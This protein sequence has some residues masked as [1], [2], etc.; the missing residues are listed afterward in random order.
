MTNT[1][2]P[3]TRKASGHSPA[4]P[5]LRLAAVALLSAIGWIAVMAGDTVSTRF[6]IAFPI[7]SHKVL[8]SFGS[9]GSALDSIESMLSD[10]RNNVCRIEISEIP[11]RRNC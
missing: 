1:S 3:P 9:N 10:R 5:L 11:A 4:S 2:P 7:N 8:R 6:E